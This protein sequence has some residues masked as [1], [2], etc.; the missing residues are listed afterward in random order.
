MNGLLGHLRKPNLHTKRRQIYNAL[1]K[2]FQ[3]G[4]LLPSSKLPDI[5]QMADHFSVSYATMHAALS[6][7]VRD[8]RLVSHRGKGIFVAE[9]S[10]DPHGRP[11][12]TNLV[13]VLPQQEDVA[14][15]GAVVEMEAVLHGCS[16]GASDSGAK[17]GILSLPSK[18]TEEDLPPVLEDLA[19]Y[20]GAIFH[21]TQYAVLM[22]ELGRRNF[23]FAMQD[24]DPSLGSGV[25][26]DR[27]HAA[28]LAAEHLLDHGHRRIAYFG[29]SHGES[30]L[31]YRSFCE[32]IKERGIADAPI[33]QPCEGVG[34]AYDAARE[35]IEKVSQVDAVFVDNF[36]K[37]RILAQILRGQRVRIPQDL[38]VMGYGTESLDAGEPPFLSH[39]AI[40]YHEMARET[41]KLLD[42]LIRGRAVPPVQKVL[43]ARLEI[44]PSCGCAIAEGAKDH[45]FQ[46]TEIET[47]RHDQ[48]VVMA[49]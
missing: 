45:L 34:D 30:A 8:G 4:H 12:M 19:G 20:D 15:Y 31:K 16:A 43:K 42:L 26:Y 48:E 35:F 1:V 10:Q 11:T 3:M 47:E 36:Q 14:A 25:T 39:M 46:Q 40:P 37:A 22:R 5:S 17:L 6:D 28:R 41:A 33:L 2:Q 9:P 7:L 23:H 49:G 21:G 13:L 44:R 32:A 27:S 24:G 38:A 29:M 18:I